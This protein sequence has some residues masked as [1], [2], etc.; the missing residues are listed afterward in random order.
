MLEYVL[1]ETVF[2]P[3]QIIIKLYLHSILYVNARILHY[4]K[5][6][7]TFNELRF[8]MLNSRS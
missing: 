4:R 6:L 7:D 3:P 8:S 1:F 2:Q 5:Y